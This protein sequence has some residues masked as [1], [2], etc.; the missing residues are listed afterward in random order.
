MT[1]SRTIHPHISD[2]ENLFLDNGLLLTSFV[3]CYFTVQP[4]DL[5][6]YNNQLMLRILTKDEGSHNRKYAD[7]LFVKPLSSLDSV[8]PRPRKARHDR[9]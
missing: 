8:Q 3:N 1:S 2:Y 9:P 7:E 6:I 5:H 4:F